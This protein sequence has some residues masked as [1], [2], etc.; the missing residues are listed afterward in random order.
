VPQ[1][2]CIKALYLWNIVSGALDVKTSDIGLQIELLPIADPVNKGLTLIKL[3]D[4]LEELFE[5]KV[6]LLTDRPIKNPYFHKSLAESKI[7]VYDRSS[8]EVP[9]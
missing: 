1:V 3:W 5:R 7:L 4:E 9:V 6:D 8:Q 2:Q